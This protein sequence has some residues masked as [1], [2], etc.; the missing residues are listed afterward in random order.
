MQDLESADKNSVGSLALL[1]KVYTA[2]VYHLSKQ[3][4]AQ[5]VGLLPAATMTTVKFLL[6]YFDKCYCL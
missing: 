3:R 4:L 1:L 6:V 2:Y 5:A